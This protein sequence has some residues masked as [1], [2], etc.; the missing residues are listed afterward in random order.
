VLRGLTQKERGELIVL[1]RRA[2][3]SA[4]PQAVWSAAEDD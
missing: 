3:A 2:L 4:P 1:L